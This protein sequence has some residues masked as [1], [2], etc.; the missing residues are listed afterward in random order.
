MRRCPPQLWGTSRLRNIPNGATRP[1]SAPPGDQGLPLQSPH[2]GIGGGGRGWGRDPCG[3][4]PCSQGGRAGHSLPSQAPV[5]SKGGIKEFRTPWAP[6]PAPRPGCL[7]PSLVGMSDL[8]CDL[9]TI[10]TIPSPQPGCPLCFPQE[11]DGQR[12]ECRRGGSLQVQHP[13]PPSG[14]R[15]HQSLH[16]SCLVG[17]GVSPGPQ[18]RWTPGAT[19]TCIG[20]SPTLSRVYVCVCVVRRGGGSR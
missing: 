9:K 7:P 8:T 18:G 13:P 20:F 17:P 19:S 2:P 10:N 16:L 5:V 6:A 4:L 3:A 12:V 15:S 1:P 11:W 14:L